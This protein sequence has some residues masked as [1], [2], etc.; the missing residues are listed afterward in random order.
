[1]QSWNEKIL[2]YAF[3]FDIHKICNIIIS[4]F[5]FCSGHVCQSSYVIRIHC[6]FS[7]WWWLLIFD[8]HIK[9]VVIY[10]PCSYSKWYPERKPECKYFFFTLDLIYGFPRLLIYKPQYPGESLLRLLWRKWPIFNI[11]S[12]MLEK[13]LIYHSIFCLDFSCTCV[14]TI[15]SNN[16]LAKIDL[17]C[18]ISICFWE[19]GASSSVA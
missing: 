3:H 4:R 18:N 12:K 10:C 1:M 19:S 14:K 7:G 16:F 9:I 13:T 8:I 17:R 2:K 15:P 6:L 11:F 5:E